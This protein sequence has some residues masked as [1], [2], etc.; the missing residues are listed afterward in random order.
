MA[1]KIGRNSNT[2]DTAELT[3]AITASNTTS[4]TVFDANSDRIAVHIS[5]DG[6]GTVKVK[7]QAASVDNDYKGDTVL[8]GQGWWFIPDNIYT[9]EISVI[10]KNASSPQIYATE[11]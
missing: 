10:A 11:Y 7:L 2:N 8:S 5:N 4:T 3:D 1:L 9:G 6:P